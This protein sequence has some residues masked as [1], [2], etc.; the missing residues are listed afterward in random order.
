[1]AG[2]ES[3]AAPRGGLVTAVDVGSLVLEAKAKKAEQRLLRKLSLQMIRIG[4]GVLEAPIH[5]YQPGG[6]EAMA[7][8]NKARDRL[9]RVFAPTRL[10]R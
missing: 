6:A 9:K 2:G 4:Y 8:L 10:G 7:R 5:P 3:R 1:M